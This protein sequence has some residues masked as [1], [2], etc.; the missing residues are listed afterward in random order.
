MI[1]AAELC[2]APLLA[3]AASS[4][5]A[6]SVLRMDGALAALALGQ[7]LSLVWF[8]DFLGLF[9][10]PS[11]QDPFVKLD[12]EVKK[13]LRSMVHGHPFE[14]MAV[15]QAVQVICMLVAYGGYAVL[16]MSDPV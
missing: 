6:K 11:S 9:W 8:V 16:R 5:G 10:D 2:A 14:F 15:S 13:Q 7:V 12:L 4:M 3:I 1:E